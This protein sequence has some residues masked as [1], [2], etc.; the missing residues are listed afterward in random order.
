VNV[1]VAEFAGRPLVTGREASLFGMRFVIPSVQEPARM[2]LAVNVGGALVPSAL[3]IYILFAGPVSPAGVL[4]GVGVVSGV[5][6]LFSRPLQGVGIVV[7]LLIPPLAAAG[8]SL[9]LAG[10]A[11]APYAYIS[12]TLGTLIGADLLNL[13]KIRALGAPVASIGGAGTFDGIFV[14]GILAVLLT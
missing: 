11:P 3:S 5:V 1:P 10:E 2:I 9:L 13:G 6:W 14:T 7:P 4:V 8:V 12:G